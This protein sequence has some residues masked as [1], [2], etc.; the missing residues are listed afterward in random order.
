MKSKSLFN[1]ENVYFRAV[2]LEKDAEPE[3]AWTRNL[4]YAGYLVNEEPARPLSVFQ[5]KKRQE[6]MQ[7]RMDERRNSFNYGIHRVSDGELIGFYRVGYVLWTVGAAW[8]RVMLGDP[9]EYHSPAGREALQMSLRYAFDELNLYRVSTAAVAC[10]LDL[11]QE[12]EQ[13][14]YV[15]EVRQR[16]AAF[17]AGQQQD[18]LVFG[19][20]RSEWSARQGE[21]A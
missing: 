21:G 14:G 20:L 9:S 12:L 17:R 11:I 3:A 19:M 8:Q 1:G 6:A 5:V 13:A 10:D 15:L 18:L 2:D 4:L 7:K 16:E